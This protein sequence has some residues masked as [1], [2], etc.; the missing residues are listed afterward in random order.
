LKEFTNNGK[1]FGGLRNLL[2]TSVLHDV[3]VIDDL[4]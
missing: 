1:A 3:M 4:V 2:I